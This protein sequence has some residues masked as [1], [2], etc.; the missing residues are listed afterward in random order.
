MKIFVIGNCHIAGMVSCLSLMLGDGPVVEGRS[1]EAPV[2]DLEEGDIVLLQTPFRANLAKFEATPA[3]VLQWPTILFSAF[4]PDITTLPSRAQS[5]VGGWH[6]SI[7]LAAWKLGLSVEDAVSLFRPEVFESLGFFNRLHPSRKHLSTLLNQIDFPG[8]RLVEKW[9]STGCFMF[10]MNHPKLH[11]VSDVARIVV[12]KLKLPT[13]MRDPAP[14]LNDPLKNSAL[15]PV[16]PAVASK[17][18]LPR[19]EMFFKGPRV[20]GEHLLYDL[21]RFIA[22]SYEIYDQAPLD[23]LNTSALDKPE[24]MELDKRVRKA[25]R[26][27]GAATTGSPYKG[28]SDFQFWRRAIETVPSREVDP[29]VSGAF[30]I[31][32]HEKVA[33]AGSC[34]AQH[35]SRTLAASGFNYFVAEKAPTGMSAEDAHSRNFGVF[36]ARFGNLYTARQLR[37]LFERA[38][39][40]FR[41]AERAWTRTDGR[42]VDPFRPAIEPDGFDSAQEVE[43]DQERHLAHVREM[44]EGWTS[45][46]LPWD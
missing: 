16:Y 26:Y 3:Q 44:F 43:E 28:L 13:Q 5:P 18:G 35:I 22:A 27:K 15:W 24:F 10:G 37:Q 29:V 46:S 34:F 9:L 14:L 7:C 32:P 45:S 23:A 20:L 6:S 33:T 31:S 36:S 2:D 8:D 17:L 11:V 4:H 25:A 12:D 1:V 39:E 38:Y 40:E 42:F 21:E 41:P 19:T 30:Q